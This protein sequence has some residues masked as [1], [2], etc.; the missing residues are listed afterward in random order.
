MKTTPVRRG[1]QDSVERKP[2]SELAQSP[3][4][5]LPTCLK[6]IRCAMARLG[7]CPSSELQDGL[8]GFHPSDSFLPSCSRHLA[9]RKLIPLQKTWKLNRGEQFRLHNLSAT[10]GT[11]VQGLQEATKKQKSSVSHFHL[12]QSTYRDPTSPKALV[13]S[14]I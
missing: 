10:E 8:Q 9:A 7:A 2:L 6:P 3:Y 14:V 5:A 12:R 13:E 11:A 4:T 1:R